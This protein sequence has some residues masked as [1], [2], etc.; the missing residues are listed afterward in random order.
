MEAT[1]TIVINPG[2]HVII[3]I[4]AKVTIVTTVVIITTITIIVRM[5]AIVVM[6]P[7]YLQ[8]GLKREVKVV[9]SLATIVIV[10]VEITQVT[11]VIIKIVAIGNT[12]KEATSAAATR[13]NHTK[14]LTTAHFHINIALTTVE[15]IIL[16]VGRV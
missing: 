6:V 13:A 4:I 12:T 11:I 1:T 5:P 10:V 7:K 16:T 15:V 2:T 3:I 14:G 9:E 8:M